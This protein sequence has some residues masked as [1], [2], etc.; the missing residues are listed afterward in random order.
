MFFSPQLRYRQRIR[1]PSGPSRIR[2]N[3]YRLPC[4]NTGTVTGG[5]LFQL[6]R[7]PHPP[8]NSIPLPLLTVA[9]SGLPDI[10]TTLTAF[11]DKPSS[12]IGTAV[13]GQGLPLQI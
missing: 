3:T 4:R 9:T 11:A 6:R 1:G 2:I 13:A 10:P 7:S 8:S 12:N 5:R